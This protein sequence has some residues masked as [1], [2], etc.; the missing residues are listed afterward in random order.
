MSQRRQ[1]SGMHGDLRDDPWNTSAGRD[2]LRQS[3]WRS[4]GGTGN[5]WD[6]VQMARAEREANTMQYTLASIESIG[7]AFEK[8]TAGLQ[9]IINLFKS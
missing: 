8:L 5:Y 2:S 7:T 3:A 9:S 6:A 1:A 4:M